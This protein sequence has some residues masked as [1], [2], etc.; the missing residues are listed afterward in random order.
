[1]SRPPRR[2][3]SW[4]IRTATCVDSTKAMIA[5]PFDDD[6]LRGGLPWRRLYTRRGSALTSPVGGLPY[7]RAWRLYTHDIAQPT[8]AFIDAKPRR[9]RE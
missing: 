1:M 6:D 8:E 9:I 2:S 4:L 7:P 3:W 5:S